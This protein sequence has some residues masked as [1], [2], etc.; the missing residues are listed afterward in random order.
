MN[1][2]R[3]R[4]LLS[5]YLDG[6]LEAETRSTLRDHLAECPDCSLYHEELKELDEDVKSLVQS[7]PEVPETFTG[8][9]LNRARRN[10]NREDDDATP[11]SSRTATTVT[12]G[13]LT[14]V[15]GLL[16]GT[17]LGYGFVNAVRNQ[18]VQLSENPSVDTGTIS[19]PAPTESASVVSFNDAYFELADAQAT[20]TRQ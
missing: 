1:C 9:L 10:L 18:P 4:Q 15:L 11:V 16:A 17:Y 7:D 20:G 19:N 5:P 12:V 8:H 14:L 13:V 3:A 2:N 6:E